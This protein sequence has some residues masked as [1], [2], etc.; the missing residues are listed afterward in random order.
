MTGKELFGI[1]QYVANFLEP[2]SDQIESFEAAADG[3]TY[4]VVVV[5]RFPVMAVREKVVTIISHDELEKLSE[6]PGGI[7]LSFRKSALIIDDDDN[8]IQQAPAEITLEEMRGMSY[9]PD[10]QPP[11]E[12]VAALKNRH[13]SV[14]VKRQIAAKPLTRQQIFDSLE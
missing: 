4:K 5:L 1:Q 3:D 10:E 11:A 7:P 9:E 6:A 14:R 13:R 8:E 12:V 2:L